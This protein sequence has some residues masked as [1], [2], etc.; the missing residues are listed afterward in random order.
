MR[1]ATTRAACAA[2]DL[3]VWDDPHTDDPR[4]ARV[5]L[6]HE[7][8]PVL[9]EALGGG[10]ATALARTGALLADDDDALSALAAGRRSSAA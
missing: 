10:V 8:L 6:R 4:Y 7:V 9:E 5:R 1:R 2:L 3:A